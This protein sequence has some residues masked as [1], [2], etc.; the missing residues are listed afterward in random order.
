MREKCTRAF[1]IA[2][3][4]LWYLAACVFVAKYASNFIDADMSSELVLAK[5]LADEGSIISKNWFYSTELRVLNTQLVFMPL[6]LLFDNWHIVRA[7]G[8]AILLAI[9]A[10]S[11]IYCARGM[12]LSLNISLICAGVLLMPISESYAYAVLKGAYYIPHI[13]ISFFLFGLYCRYVESDSVKGRRVKLIAA[14]LL[15]FVSGLGGIR[16]IFVFTFPMALAAVMLYYASAMQL[17]FGRCSD[18]GDTKTKGKRLCVVSVLSL[19]TSCVGFI[20]NKSVLSR[21]YSFSDYAMDYQGKAILFSSFKFSG[22]E[23]FINSI[24]GFFGFKSGTVFSGFLLYNIL[25]VIL[26]AVCVLSIKFVLGKTENTFV[27]K[28]VA[29][30][31]LAGTAIFVFLYGFTDIERVERYSAPIFVFAVFVVGSVFENLKVDKKLKIYASTI[32][33]AL[34]TVCNLNTYR[35][36][37]NNDRNVYSKDIA[38]VIQ[39]ENIHEGYSSFWSG[40]LITELSNGDIEM[41]LIGTDYIREPGDMAYVYNWLQ[42]KSHVA[43]VPEGRFFLLLSRTEYDVSCELPRTPDYT[44]FAYALYFFD[45]YEDFTALYST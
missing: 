4:A 15:A 37:G 25:F 43:S 28:A 24:C 21:I 11:A 30:F 20:I 38:E 26:I 34:L 22:I 42:E 16:Q 10:A 8:T 39:K 7:L 3:L 12:K 9:L 14:L 40:N 33:L 13:C 27:Q 45:D 29:C 31:V 2:W 17:N 32:I 35:Q 36:A 1:S 44:N 6:F 18:D 5:L 41:R 19:I 23:F